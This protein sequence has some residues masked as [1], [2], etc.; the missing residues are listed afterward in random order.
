MSA[1]RLVT[2][3]NH[4]DAVYS[5][6]TLRS[7]LRRLL[8]RRTMLSVRDGSIN[9][10][11]NGKGLNELEDTV[12]SS[13][14]SFADLWDSTSV[15]IRDQG[16][17]P[18]GDFNATTSLLLTCKNQVIYPYFYILSLVAW[19]PFHIQSF[20]YQ[21][22]SVRKILN[23]LYTLFIFILIIFSYASSIIACQAR[24]EIKEV[25]L[26]TTVGP[27]EPP[28]TKQPI[29]HSNIST[30]P[31]SNLTNATTVMP[32]HS[33]QHYK[34]NISNSS[35]PTSASNTSN[36]L[37]LSTA[38]IPSTSANL[39]THHFMT[40]Q[41]ILTASPIVWKPA[42][43]ECTHIFSTYVVPNV[44]HFLAFAIGFY[45]FRIQESEGLH[46]LI[47]KVFLLSSV[48]KKIV[49]RLRFFL[50]GGIFMVI[51]GVGNFILF[52]YAF[53]LN[54]VTGFKDTRP[55]AQWT[56]VS[57]MVLG[58]IVELCVSVVTIV[59]YCAQCELL[60]FYLREIGLRMEEKTKDLNI[61]MKDVLEVKKNLSRVN[62]LISVIAT[63]IV[64]NYF[65][66]SVIG[67]C[68]LA[69]YL[70]EIKCIYQLLFRVFKPLISFIMI[71]FPIA[72]AAR[73]TSAARQFKQKSLQIRVFGYPSA[74]QL[75]L[76]SFVLFSHSAD[77]KAKLLFMPVQGSFLSGV[78]AL[79]VFV[80]LLMLQSG[81]LAGRNRYL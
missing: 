35:V 9:S 27:P 15:E 2:Q 6:N 57:L 77:M 22:C 38:I 66:L 18:K 64:F 23:I 81:I 37:N 70:P 59:N 69:I 28:T 63:L 8:P 43:T 5:S 51:L 13:R 1:E 41:P 29:T 73:L 14:S 42:V 45:L 55:S 24:L 16:S 56:A 7:A 47:E 78:A 68:N 61:I 32:T 53:S 80:L 12:G 71:I 49:S 17:N 20:R 50:F 74:S 62:G 72:I 4:W 33:T 52:C 79:M 3:T 54:S 60:I 76:D 31:A 39:T 34:F 10:S 75:D 46:A 40:W 36:W 21:G 65:E 25:H 44:L 11:G 26:Q 67:V 19:R 30:T 48:P 58:K